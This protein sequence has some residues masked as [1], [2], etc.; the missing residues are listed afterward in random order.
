[1]DLLTGNR[2]KRLVFD[3]SSNSFRRD[4]TFFTRSGWHQHGEF[5]TAVTK[6]RVRSSQAAFDY[7]PKPHQDLIP[8]DMDVCG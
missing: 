7:V 6:G 3:F 2:R 8:I 1:V 5:F 4:G